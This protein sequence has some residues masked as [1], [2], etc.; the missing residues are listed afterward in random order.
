[1][2]QKKRL[3]QLESEYAL[4]I[5]KLKEAQALRQ[6]GNPII[7]CSVTQPSLH[8]LTQDKLALA[9]DDPADDPEPEGAEPQPVIADVPTAAPRRRSFRDSGSFTKPNLS[10]TETPVTPTTLTTP[11]LSIKQA[12]PTAELLGLLGVS[13]EDL[14]LRYQQCQRKPLRC[15]RAC[16]WRS[17]TAAPCWRV[18]VSCMQK[19]EMW[20]E[21]RVCG[22]VHTG[23][24]HT[25]PE[26][27]LDVPSEDL[28]RSVPS[29]PSDLQ[30]QIPY[31]H[32]THSSVEQQNGELWKKPLKEE[33][34][35]EDFTYGETS[36]SLENFTPEDQQ[37]LGLQIILKEEEPEHDD[38]LCNTTSHPNNKSMIRFIPRENGVHSIHVKF[39][40]SHIPGS[41]FNV[42]VG[43]AG[44][45]G[46]PGLVSAYGA[47]LQAGCTGVPAEFVVNTSNAGSG[48]L[49]VII[50]GPSKV[51]MDCS[52]CVDGY[53][54]TYTPMAPG[55]Y[56]ISIKYGGPQHIV[57]SPFKAR[58]TDD[59]EE[60][61]KHWKSHCCPVHHQT[62]QDTEQADQH[63]NEE[64][65]RADRR[66]AEETER[67]DR[68]T[69][70]LESNECS[71][72]GGE[73]EI[74]LEIM[75][76]SVVHRWNTSP[77]GDQSPAALTASH[78]IWH[79]D[80]AEVRTQRGDGGGKGR[81][82]RRRRR[83]GRVLVKRCS[84]LST[85]VLGKFSQELHK[86]QTF[87]RTDVGAGTPG[88]KR[89]T[90]YQEALEIA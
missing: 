29:L 84:S 90:Y 9:S 23:S 20:P 78:L 54:I 68:Q 83:E 24:A 33:E 34:T 31:L 89:S 63:G 62:D 52:E 5:Q 3:Q 39:N 47:G 42:R 79:W 41:P 17:L 77:S 19:V 53:K 32:L 26:F 16:W 1:M 70:N 58:V 21:R 44:H 6:A 76:K 18:S 50:D 55:N 46:D 48:A 35:D 2:V 73:E 67:A 51:K 27:L 30:D 86:L 12:T 38:Y 87:P 49:S 14:R 82:K 85:C 4:K 59:P 61:L 10:H 15:V 57:G 22:C 74:C 75:E 37:N 40:G 56:L 45:A 69:D 7:P 88:K 66:A 36:S 25:T 8:D 80:R 28:H 64:T 81:L 72:E 60:T 43:D 71:D 65:E 13:V 11:T